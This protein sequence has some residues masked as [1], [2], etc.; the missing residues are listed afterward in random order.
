MPH[1]SVTMATETIHNPKEPRHYMRIRP[2]KGCVRVKRGD[3]VLAQTNDAV[4]VI[5]VAYD[6][7]DSVTYVPRADISPDLSVVP[8]KTTHC[9]LKGDARYFALDGGDPIAW[10][11]NT[12]FDFA[13]ELKGRVAFYRDKVTIE[14]IGPDA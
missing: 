7:Y 8:E 3:R 14:E 2:V 5:E 9:P 4:R 6:V 12:P 10:T 1:P 11:Y 13:D